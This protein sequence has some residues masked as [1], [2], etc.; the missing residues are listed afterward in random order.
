MPRSTVSRHV[1]SGVGSCGPRSA[2]SADTSAGNGP[3]AGNPNKGPGNN[4]GKGPK[5][6]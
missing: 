2:G 3:G 1:G 6:P 4:N 5:K